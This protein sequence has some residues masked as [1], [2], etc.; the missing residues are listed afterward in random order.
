MLHPGLRWLHRSCLGS[1]QPDPEIRND[2][3]CLVFVLILIHITVKAQFIDNF[4]DGNF[5]SNPSWS[6]DTAAFEINSQDQLHL[7]STGSDTSCL[8]TASTR[9]ANT[10]WSFWI[11]MSFNTSL[12]NYARIYLTSDSPMKKSAVNANY[13]QF[14]GS[15]DSIVF[16][17][18]EGN[19]RTPLFTFPGIRTNKSIN[20]IRIKVFRDSTGNW[21]LFA[22][23]SGGQNFVPAGVF[24]D[25][26]ILPVTCF[27]IFCRYT[28]SNASKFYFD[29]FYVGDIIYDT[30][31]PKIQSVSFSDSNTI[32]IRFTEPVDTSSLNMAANFSLKNNSVMLQ[33]LHRNKD[34]PSVIF[35]TINRNENVFFCDS[36]LVHNIRDFSWNL[37]QDTSVFFCYYIPGIC[38]ENDLVINEILF[39]PDAGGAR[40]IELFNRSSRLIG[41]K[42]LCIA[43]R[44]P[45]K[46]KGPL[47]P[48]SGEDRFLSPSDY[49]VLTSDSLKLC[50][51][52]FV[53][54]PGKVREVS[55][56]PSMDPDSGEVFLFR[57]PDTTVIDRMSYNKSMHLSYLVIT[58]GVSLE[59]LNPDIPS[60]YSSN[61]QSASETSGYA[62]P[63]YENSHHYFN[64]ENNLDL[65][66]S[67]ISPDND[68]KK[69]LLLI[70]V[71]T[72][73]PGIMVS[74]RIYDIRGKLV[75]IITDRSFIG[76]KSLFV[77]DG[78]ND[79]RQ[80][81]TMGYYL[82]LVDGN[83]AD[84]NRSKVKKT[85]VVAHALN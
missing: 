31:P 76:N 66:N 82:I 33:E 71:N 42:S 3:R 12:N 75:R 20:S 9:L 24:P 54:Y 78:T 17:R 56:F 16:Y 41:L 47:I 19:T 44:L 70:R 63:S 53:P 48:I 85:V 10:E 46:V 51:K 80:I 62:T 29:D 74:V 26:E 64:S 39:D 18:Q 52:Y 6:G 13:I 15:G 67:I 60:G 58:K 37:L 1:S 30:V 27:G 43:T 25:K 36:I 81:V 84:G 45:G 69:D 23:S 2:M 8:T 65:D 68:G 59:R 73:N 72:S 22:D 14:G 79:N 49:F 55:K 40:F 35:I 7:N 4:S 32:Q 77:W 5:T 28:S 61:W 11:K 21:N 83:D 38:M 50:S 57:V 34:D